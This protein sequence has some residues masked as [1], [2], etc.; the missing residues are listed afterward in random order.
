MTFDVERALREVANARRRDDQLTA[1][2]ARIAE[3]MVA[4]FRGDFGGVLDMETCGQALLI[5]AASLVPLCGPEI[6]GT[7]LANMIG[8]AG[9]SLVRGA[10][11]G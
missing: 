11:N 8:F 6:P 4:G 9:E 5:A 10:R 1:E 2:T 7:V 3:L